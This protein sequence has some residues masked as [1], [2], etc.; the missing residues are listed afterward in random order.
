MKANRDNK[1]VI[2]KLI[3]Y[4]GFES[5][6]AVISLLLAAATV[7]LTLYIPVLTGRAVDVCIKAGNVDFPVVRTTILQ[8]MVCA[9]LSAVCQWLMALCNNS[10]AYHVVQ[11]IRNDA[12]RKISKLPINYF[13]THAQGDIVSRIMAD[14]EQLSDGL[15][16]GFTQA[17]TGVLT[18]LVTL[19]FMLRLNPIITIAVVVLTPLSLFVS[20]FIAKHTH[21]MFKL[22][23]ET[24]GEQTALID[25]MITGQ[26]AVN[27]YNQKDEE[28]ARFDEINKRLADCSMKATFY[29]SLVN[30]STRFVNSCVYAAVGIFGAIFAI[31]GGITVGEL[32]AFLSY[33]GQ[34]TKPFNEIS[35]VVT[36]LQNAIVCAG[37]VFD[38]LEEKDMVEVVDGIDATPIEKEGN[39]L[40]S[41]E[42]VAFSYL[43]E[44]PLIT[45][46]SLDVYEGQKIA[47]VGPTGC[48][49]TTLINLLMRFYDVKNGAI[50][51][52]GQD[53]RSMERKKLRENIGMVLQDTWLKTGTVRD[54]IA[55]NKPDATDEEIIEAAKKAHAHSFIKRLPD[56]YNTKVGEKG[57]QLS[58][59]Q[60]Q[61]LCIARVMLVLPPVL[62]LDEA[63]SSIDTRTEIRIQ[64]AF[65]EM[66]KGR[67]SFVVAHRLS[68]IMGSDKIIVM[69][70]GNI[71]EIGNHT[72]L[73][74]QNGF[75]AKLYNA[76]F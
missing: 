56:G 13:D 63:T 58:Q 2:K 52:K 16:M 23:S 31:S 21:D 1:K 7:V 32:S 9:A 74:A 4:I 76:Q 61:L 20:S 47:I 28:C 38:F 53:I 30:P 22:Q 57:V 29:S 26:K 10:I 49:K 68:T 40:V 67:T 71:V 3:N 24:K 41:I 8:I 39:P 50:R 45:D 19:F 46:F 34:Y 33:A 69:N 42:H 44:R 65:N 15:L 70:A 36:E 60:Q 35:G 5:A 54:N 27:A 25:E 62:I 75:Y 43:P 18:I 59:G 51:L 37:R 66:M 72:E 12:F 55:M 14:V 48:G 6:K 73:M 64:K 11:R 17:F